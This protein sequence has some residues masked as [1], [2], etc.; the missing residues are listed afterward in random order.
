[1][2][3]YGEASPLIGFSK[4]TIKEINWGIESFIAAIELN[5]NYSLERIINPCG[6]TL[7]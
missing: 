7:S 4:E 5:Y 6:N 2:I 3:G 1:M